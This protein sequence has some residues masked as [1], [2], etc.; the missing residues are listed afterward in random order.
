METSGREERRRVYIAFN[1]QGKLFSYIF[2][3]ARFKELYNHGNTQSLVMMSKLHQQRKQHPCDGR[4]GVPHL[5][6]GLFPWSHVGALCITVGVDDIVRVSL[7]IL[8]CVHSHVPTTMSISFRL[9]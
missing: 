8:H 1:S 4:D 6:S 5:R 3:I 7:A 9:E 2:L